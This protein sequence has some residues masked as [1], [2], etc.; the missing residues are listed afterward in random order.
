MLNLRIW[1]YNEVWMVHN[2]RI[3]SLFGKLFALFED[4][5]RVLVYRMF[6]DQDVSLVR[7][8]QSNLIQ[9]LP[10]FLRLTFIK[11]FGQSIRRCLVSSRF[12]QN[13][14]VLQ[15]LLSFDFRIWFGH[16]LREYFPIRYSSPRTYNIERAFVQS[17]RVV[18]SDRL[19]LLLRCGCVWVEWEFLELWLLRLW[20]DGYLGVLQGV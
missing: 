18:S 5:C 16:L 9:L 15:H 13:V 11:C 3:K 10:D 7:L 14:L 17:N 20:I 19:W 8:L 12:A 1:S 6:T 4:L 2:L